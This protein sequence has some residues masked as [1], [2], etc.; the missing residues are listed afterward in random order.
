V[1]RLS[2]LFGRNV[3]LSKMRLVGAVI[4][5]LAL[6]VVTSAGTVETSLQRIDSLLNEITDELRVVREAVAG[7]SVQAQAGVDTA[8]VADTVPVPETQTVERDDIDTAGQG[9][10]D[11]L[12]VEVAEPEAGGGEDGLP[13]GMLWRTGVGLYAGGYFAMDD[14]AWDIGF[15]LNGMQWFGKWGAKLVA[16]G[17]DLGPADWHLLLFGQG[18]RTIARWVPRDHDMFHLYALGGLGF[19][20]AEYGYDMGVGSDGYYWYDYSWKYGDTPYSKPDVIVGGALGLGLEVNLF[21]GIKLG[22]ELGYRTS[23]YARRYQ[24]LP[25]YGGTER[26]S[27]DWSLGLFYSLNLYVYF[28]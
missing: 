2:V 23:Y 22:N 17:I 12:V 7:D 13:E 15:G 5:V 25:E 8:E 18:M 14:M 28:R 11:S 16:G 10:G 3:S 26:P 9:G 19:Y 24:D 21:D 1:E 20:M 4:P 6:S 27:S